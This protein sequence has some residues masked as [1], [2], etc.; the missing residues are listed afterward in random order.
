MRNL[1][2]ICGAAV[3]DNVAAIIPRA[4]LN[5]DKG[6]KRSIDACI[7]MGF[8]EKILRDTI[9]LGNLPIIKYMLALGM[10]YNST[11]INYVC[12]YG[13]ADV[14]IYLIENYRGNIDFN[15]LLLRVLNKTMGEKTISDVLE[16]QHMIKYL[17]SRGAD[18][19][20]ITADYRQKFHL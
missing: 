5:I 8:I 10:H 13:Y 3:I 19:N 14:L 15:D 20:L 4:A 11:D 18:P 7:N 1:A 6:L 16:S 17:I 2:R 12:T 9:K